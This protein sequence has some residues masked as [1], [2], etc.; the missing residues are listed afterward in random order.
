MPLYMLLCTDRP[1]AIE[2]RKANRTAHL[3]HVA[4]TGC[5][6]LAGPLLDEAGEMAGSLI[7]LDRPD[8]ASARAWSEA[9]PYAT[10]GLFESV[11]VQEWKRVVG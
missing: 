6:V 2:T 1:G 3:D 8:I 4:R 11:R 7:I 5:V 10:A 9:D